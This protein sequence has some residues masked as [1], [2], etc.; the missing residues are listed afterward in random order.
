MAKVVLFAL[1]LAACAPRQ[2][3]VDGP[4]TRPA[5]PSGVVSVALVGGLVY[6]CLESGALITWKVSESV[7]RS[8]GLGRVVALAKDGSVAVTAT[9]GSRETRLEV[10]ALDTRT[11]VST[12]HFDDGVDRVLAASR[13]AVALLVTRP[14]DPDAPAIPA[15][16]PPRSYGALW[17]LA[18]NAIISMPGL[19]HC[20]GPFD[21]SADAERFA[22][23]G[24]D[25]T[26]INRRT[27]RTMVAD[28]APDWSSAGPPAGAGGRPGPK[29]SYEFFPY[30][31]LS[32]RVGPGGSDVYFTY[33]GTEAQRDWR[34]ERW[35]PE[36]SRGGAAPATHGTLVRLASTPGGSARLLA[37]S[38]D[39]NLLILGHGEPL[40]V[41]RAPHYESERLASEGARA[42]A[43][44]LS[45]DGERIVSGH[46]D[47][48]LRM[49]D[50][51]TGRLLATTSP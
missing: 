24:G 46:S 9:H 43:A 15:V 27:N 30:D 33:Q 36:R 10:W 17:Q 1:T 40:T 47:G 11:L 48:R 38:P 45:P 7:P 22:C 39:G 2:A 32:L 41:R 3:R 28:L 20:E 35:T 25:L 29:P 23:G 14:P 12:R 44:T 4:A 51:R 26:W 42:T 50:A 5:R 21:M 19:D 13:A 37:A 6:A 16:P 8:L 18:P 31:V 34:L 49:W